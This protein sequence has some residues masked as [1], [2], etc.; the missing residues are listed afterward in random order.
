MTGANTLWVGERQPSDRP[1]VEWADQLTGGLAAIDRREAEG[2]R[3]DAVVA[4][5][6]P[7]DA[8]RLFEHAH[9]AWPDVACFLYGEIEHGGFEGI[10]VCGAAASARLTPDEFLNRVVGA[11]HSQRP[12]PLADDEQARLAV[13]KELS[14]EDGAFDEAADRLVGATE[15]PMALVGLVDDHTLRVVGLSGVGAG[16]AP[17]LCRGEVVCAHALFA[18]EPLEVTD[19]KTDPRSRSTAL[20]DRL[21]LRSYLGRPVEVAGQPVGTV[22][23]IDARPRRFGSDERAALRERAAAVEAELAASHAGRP[24]PPTHTSD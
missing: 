9:T 14:V 22:A 5:A 6:V 13:L 7:E 18:D 23:L 16:A 2:G 24:A 8:D 11:A 12:Y 4:P 17:P 21:G 3:F 1:G 15:A 20:T 19:L 10:A